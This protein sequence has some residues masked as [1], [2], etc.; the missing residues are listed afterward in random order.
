MVTTEGPLQSRFQS[1]TNNK[2]SFVNQCIYLLYFDLV[3]S[4]FCLHRIRPRSLTFHA[5][6]LFRFDLGIT[7][8]PASAIN[9]HEF[10]YAKPWCNVF[11]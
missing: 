5:F 1:S 11:S 9:I 2:N 6:L 10:K 8:S 3:D 7:F 4:N